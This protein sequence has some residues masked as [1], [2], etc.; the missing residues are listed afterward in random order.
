M[1]Y[2][3]VWIS[4]THL[5]TKGC[6]VELL[7]D[8]LRENKFQTLFLV[9]DIIDFWALKRS[10]YWPES[11]NAVIQEILKKSRLGTRV[12]YIQGNHDPVDHFLKGLVGDHPFDFGSILV[13]KRYVYK[14]IRLKSFLVLHGDDFDLCFQYAPFLVRLGDR[15]YEIL[16]AVNKLLQKSFKFF[17]M[18][19]EWSL[20]RSVKHSVKSI[21]KFI[22]DYESLVAKTA[23]QEK[24][25]GVICGHIHSPS[26]R[27]IHGVQYYN[28][29]DWVENCTAL[30]ES[31]DGEMK[32]I[33]WIM[34]DKNFYPQPLMVP[35]LSTK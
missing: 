22:E 15:G 35:S 17:K 5:G 19:L 11:H 27:V 10:W 28:T 14:S 31:F 20:S 25:H 13:V 9:G 32:I 8:F 12:V 21:I 26:D 18:T 7:L 4:D 3:T 23:A 6:Q 1:N 30:V 2:K 16:L 24:C 33:R 34:T 29:G